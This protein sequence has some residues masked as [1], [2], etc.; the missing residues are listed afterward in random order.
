MLVLILA[1]AIEGTGRYWRPSLKRLQAGNHVSERTAVSIA[2]PE[3]SPFFVAGA[4][5]TF[6]SIRELLRV[7][8]GAASAAVRLSHFGK[9]FPASILH[10]KLCRLI[11]ALIGT[12]I[13]FRLVG[14]EAVGVFAR[15]VL[16]HGAGA[17]LPD[18]PLGYILVTAGP[19]RLV[20]RRLV[21]ETGIAEDQAR[22]LVAFLGLTGHRSYERPE[23]DR[24]V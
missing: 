14:L 21:K 10:R 20:V 7:S 15:R 9:A 11:P 23:N 12:L 22:E 2:G 1:K 19:D 16:Q 18:S 17:E 3:T 4:S 13:R 24:A 6:L 5:S 8:N